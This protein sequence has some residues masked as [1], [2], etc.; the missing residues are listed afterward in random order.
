M[1]CPSRSNPQRKSQSYLTG[2]SGCSQKSRWR[3]WRRSWRSTLKHLSII[4]FVIKMGQQ[5][6]LLKKTTPCRFQS[7]FCKN[8]RLN[9]TSPSTTRSTPLLLTSWTSSTKMQCN[10]YCNPRRQE[11]TNN[12]LQI[13]ILQRIFNKS[14]LEEWHWKVL[15]KDDE[16]MISEE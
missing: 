4:R 8:S 12:L 15:L 14:E 1:I 10:R 13:L 11:N 2:T 7:P 6:V 3:M 9:S 5:R 16:C